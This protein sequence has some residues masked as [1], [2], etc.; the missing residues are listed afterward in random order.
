MAT[1]CL[2]VL[3]L[4]ACGWSEAPT[5]TGDPGSERLDILATDPVS[6]ALLILSFISPSGVM[7][8]MPRAYQVSAS[9]RPIA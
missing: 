1:I 6:A 3:V 2:A 9:A 8:G 7:A 5:D 4:T